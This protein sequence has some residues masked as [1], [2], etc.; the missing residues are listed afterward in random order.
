MRSGNV[1]RTC[2]VLKIGG[3][4]SARTSVFQTNG[5]WQYG[6]SLLVAIGTLIVLAWA[7]F[8]ISA[9]PDDGLYWLAR[10]AGVVLVQPGSPAQV[11]GLQ[12]NDRVILVDGAVPVVSGLRYAQKTIGDR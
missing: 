1:D 11:S 2:T 9:V 10:E 8:L 7:S 5:R 6:V 12:N 4:M 3:C